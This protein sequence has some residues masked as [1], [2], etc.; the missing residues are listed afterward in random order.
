MD[1][2]PNSR[3]TAFLSLLTIIGMIILPMI[4]ANQSFANNIGAPSSDPESCAHQDTAN[5]NGVVCWVAYGDSLGSGGTTSEE[6]RYYT[7]TG[8]TTDQRIDT[9]H[10]L[11]GASASHTLTFGV[12]G[13]HRL[14]DLTFTTTTVNGWTFSAGSSCDVITGG[15]EAFSGADASQELAPITWGTLTP[16]PPVPWCS[17]SDYNDAK[18]SWIATSTPQFHVRFHWSN[19][20][21]PSAGWTVV[22]PDPGTS[23]GSIGTVRTS[24]TVDGFPNYYEGFFT[25][26][27]LSTMTA[28]IYVGADGSGHPGC[29]ISLTVSGSPLDGTPGL[30]DTGND[31]QTSTNTNCGFSLN[32]FHY[33]KCLFEPSSSLQQWSDLENTAKTHPPISLIVGGISY[34]STGVSA[35][36]DTTGHPG[37]GSGGSVPDCAAFVGPGVG[38]STNGSADLIQAACNEMTG[39]TSDHATGTPWGE[40]IYYLLEAAIGGFFL[41]RIWALIA[42][43]FGTKDNGA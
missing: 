25:L 35:F 9:A 34:I 10:C 38:S 32:P 12:D 8:S 4:M 28:R 37:C 26:T 21:L 11:N 33:L 24:D 31:T 15:S 39:C 17:S 5:F 14:V 18:A 16:P 20:I 42:A 6:F 7:P 13:T 29:Y 23:T 3:R 40:A 2:T 43:S 27:S 22:A 30:G 36:G 41:F 19:P 1:I